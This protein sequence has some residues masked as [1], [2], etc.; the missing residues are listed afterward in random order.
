MRKARAAAAVGFSAVVSGCAFLSGGIVLL[1]MLAIVADVFARA[2]FNAPLAWVNELTEYGLYYITFLSAAWL[3][4]VDGHVKADI[5]LTL[6]KDDRRLVMQTINAA[7][8]ATSTMALAVIS[9]N[10]TWDNYLA[11]TMI[12]KVWSVP[13]YLLVLAVPVGSGLLA[14]EFTR[15]FFCNVRSIGKHRKNREMK[16]E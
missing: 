1:L 16:G 3:L 15:Q 7:L 9:A 10:F 11:G 2:V 13:R 6:A 12:F 4:R 14:V 5:F 8:G